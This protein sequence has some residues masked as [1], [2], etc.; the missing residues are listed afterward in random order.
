MMF[1]NKH[2]TIIL[3]K[4]DLLILVHV[5]F[6]IYQYKIKLYLLNCLELT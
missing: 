2:F 6:S 4:D 5:N 3:L 1:N